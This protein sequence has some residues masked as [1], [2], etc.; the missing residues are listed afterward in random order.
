[1]LHILKQIAKTGLKIE[2]A[3][4]RRGVVAARLQRDIVRT[5]GRRSPSARWTP[6]RAAV[7]ARDPRTSNPYYNIE[8]LGILRRQPAPRRH[9]AGHG[10]GVA[11]ATLKRTYDATPDPKLVVA[12]GECGCNGGIFGESY[13]SLG[14]VAN[15]IPVDVEIGPPADADR[16]AARILAAITAYAPPTPASS[17]R[18]GRHLDDPRTP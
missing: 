4:T 6:A 14:R 5:L 1:M 12:A 7:R 10:A 17:G 2:A 3:P 13:A 15:V 16:A 8:G 9:A 18:R 11:A